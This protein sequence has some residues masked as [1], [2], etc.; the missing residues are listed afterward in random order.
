MGCGGTVNG[1]VVGV[2]REAVAVVVGP[3]REPARERRAVAVATDAMELLRP[4]SDLA[5]L[6]E[7]FGS[8]DVLL[9][10]GDEL[11]GPDDEDNNEADDDPGAGADEVRERAA[12]LGHPDLVVQRLGLRPPLG[13]AA[14]PDLVAAMSELVGFD[15]EAGVYCLAP[16]SPPPGAS[17][18]VDPSRIAVVHAAQRIAQVY[19][20]P[21]LR[22]RCLELA[23][24]D[25]PSGPP[26]A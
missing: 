22:Y 5:R 16:A 17:S 15:P 8:A 25:E 7:S 21:L 11:A 24:V 6:L 23:V 14:E 12:A 1:A 10:V 18:P 9:A 4:R 26:A 2:P 20:I 19:G 13:P 3:P